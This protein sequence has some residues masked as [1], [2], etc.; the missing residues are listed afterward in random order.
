MICLPLALFIPISLIFNDPLNSAI[1][2]PA[3]VVD[4]DGR[5]RFIVFKTVD[6][7]AA[8]TIGVD[9]LVCRQS[10]FFQRFEKRFV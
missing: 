7:T 1:E 2:D 9:K 4:S 8:E 10:L 6:K 5:D 3:E